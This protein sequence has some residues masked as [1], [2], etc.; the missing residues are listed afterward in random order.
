MSNT[1]RIKRRAAGGSPG[2]PSSLENAELAFNEQDDTLYYGKGTG[3]SGGSAS[4]AM[5][6]G[7]PGAYVD[8]NSAQTVGGEKTFTQTIQGSVTGN[9]GTGTKL[10]NGRDF[11]ITG[12][13]SAPGVTFDGSGNVQ[14]NAV[15]ATTGISAGTYTKLT[16]DAKGRATGGSQA[17]ISD[18]SS[19]VGNISWGGNRI[20]NLADPLND[21]DA[22]T[23]AYVDASRQGLDAKESVRSATTSSISLSGEQTVDGV[24]L[25]SGDRVLVKNQTTAS[26]NGIYTVSSASWSRTDDANADAEVTSG[27]FVFVEEGNSNSGSGW[28]LNTPDPITVGA[29]NLNFIQFSKADEIQAGTNL[30]KSGNTISIS[31]N[32]EGQSSITTLGTITTGAWQASVIALAYGGTG[33]ALNGDSNGTIYKKDGSQLVPANAG[34]DYLSNQSTID[35]GTF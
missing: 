33:R 21:Q 27:L 4:S 19:P 15:L 35:G 1:I 34:S 18:L 17:S 31:S 11:S 13:V 30:T 8:K 14:L 32:Y 6:I 3:G 9:A 10:S 28:V 20:T 26:E 5:P 25:Q 23:K 2:A 22:A 16:V 7:G 24:S 29:T 12:D